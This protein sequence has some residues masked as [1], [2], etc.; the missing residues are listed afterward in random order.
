MLKK[1]SIIETVFDYLKNKMTLV[2]SKHRSPINALAHII[3]T[4]VPYSLKK[5]KPKI[6]YYAKNHNLH[7]PA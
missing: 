3:S 1:R 4:L 2:H 6:N 5:S 7:H